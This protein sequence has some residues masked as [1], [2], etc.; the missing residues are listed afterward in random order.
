MRAEGQ[1]QAYDFYGD[2][3]QDERPAGS[4][5]GQH[6]RGGKRDDPTGEQEQKPREFH[7]SQNITNRWNGGSKKELIPCIETFYE[8]MGTIAF[9]MLSNRLFTTFLC[10]ATWARR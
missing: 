1:D 6:R 9:T 2:S 7:A 10:G 4:W 3:G 5:L 8:Q